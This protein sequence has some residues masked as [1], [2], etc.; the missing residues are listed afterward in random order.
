MNEITQ[1]NIEI[2]T[3]KEEKFHTNKVSLNLMA[4]NKRLLSVIE[5]CQHQ[6][7][8]KDNEIM[9]S[10]KSQITEGSIILNE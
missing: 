8:Q 9:N 3:L 1:K 10:S 7:D 4:E 6:L 2:T 5:D